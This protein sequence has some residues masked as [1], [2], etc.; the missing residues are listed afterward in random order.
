M[1]KVK[2]DGEEFDVPKA[3]VDEAGG[4]GPYRILRASE[5][6][7]RKANE[8][9]AE[10]RRLAAQM[11]QQQPQPAPQRQSDKDIM[12]NLAAAR[13]GTDEEYTAALDAAFSRGRVD[14]SG[15]VREAV[16]EMQKTQATAEFQR[17]FPD[18]TGNP[19]ALRLAVSLENEVVE[20]VKQASQ[21]GQIRGPLDWQKIY[22]T[23][24]T[25]VR[26]ALG[27][28]ARQSQPATTSVAAATTA[29]TQPGNPSP[30]SE[31][32]ARKATIV[33]LPTAAARA[34]QPEEPKPETREES[35]NRMRAR[36][37]L[38]TV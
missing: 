16:T 26:N 25:Q 3:E 7:L 19:M 17:D 35:L 1:V 34:T 24:G 9:L 2:V 36:R 32:E 23:I 4:I 12:A 14:P 30:V 28:P 15:I 33:T 13:F 18:V 21:Q 10:S 6:R 27:G 38:P 31:K 20:Q 11:V 29:A 37:G 8:T 5:N 22:R